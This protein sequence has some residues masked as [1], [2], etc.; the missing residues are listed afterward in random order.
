[1]AYQH[2]IQVNEAATK[3]ITPITGTAGLQVIFGTAPVHL[4][5]DPKKAANE[6]YMFTNFKEAAETLGYS[7]DFEKYTLCGS[8]YVSLSQ[9]GIAPIILCNVLDPTIH[10][11]ELEELEKLEKEDK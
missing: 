11:K 5:A 9:K 10:K 2:G 1:M 3:I 6:L 4:A 8:M 7:D